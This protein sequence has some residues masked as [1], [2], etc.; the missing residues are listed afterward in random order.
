M[1]LFFGK[2]GQLARSFEATQPSSLEGQTVFV[3][4]QEANFERPDLLAGFL[5]H[6]GPRIVVLCAAYT[7]VDKAEE[8]RALAEKIN[9]QAP[10]EIARW[11]G[12]NDALLIHFSTDYVFSGEGQSPWKETDPTG[13]RNWYGETKLHGEQ[14]IQATGCQHLIFRTSWVFSEYGKNFLKTML[15][16]GKD[17]ETLQ[18]VDDQIG[19]PTYAP[20][21]A[22][23]VWGLIERFTQGEKLKS[24]VY[25]LA[26]TGETNWADFARAIFDEARKLRFDLEI[27]NVVG[28]PSS[29][30]PTAAERPLNSRLDQSKVKS[31]FGIQMP[32]WQE[33]TQLCL[34]RTGPVK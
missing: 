34:K 1:I 28:I 30:Y 17:K 9:V 22:R 25:H 33:S 10:Q 11:C 14:A 26:G 29:Q 23:A 7:Q 32:S 20:D 12:M 19:S 15:R 18:V 27:Q 24:G 2:H 8:D 3:S 13:P 31:V 16:L 21:L 5:D 4:S 6:Q